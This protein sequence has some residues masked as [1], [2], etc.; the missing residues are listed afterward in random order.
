MADHEVLTWER[1][2][3]AGR[4]LAQQVQ[5]DGFEPTMILSI[6]HWVQALPHSTVLCPA[7]PVAALHTGPVPT[8]RTVR[9]ESQVTAATVRTP[10]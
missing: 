6:A 9:A 2:G 8:G 10:M 4:E 7:W 1:F 3:V 5:A